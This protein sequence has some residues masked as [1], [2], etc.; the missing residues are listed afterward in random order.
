[1][2]S[3]DIIF[4]N[5]SDNYKSLALV[6]KKDMFPCQDSVLLDGFLFVDLLSFCHFPSF[7]LLTLYRKKNCSANGFL[8]ALTSIMQ[9]K[10]PDIIL[11][12][13]HEN[14]LQKNNICSRLEY[15]TNCDRDNSYKR[16][17]IR[18]YIS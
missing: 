17:I 3:F 9:S 18:S 5:S 7:K 15:Q 8:Q 10:Q 1:M 16:V 14:C 11:G 12:D 4:S 2:P 6:F 13:F